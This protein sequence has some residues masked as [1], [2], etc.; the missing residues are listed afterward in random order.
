MSADPRSPEWLAEKGIDKAIWDARGCKRYERGDRWVKEEFREFLPR[1]RLG[2]VTKVVN[3]SA[4]WFMPKHAPPGF[5]PIPPQL[6]PDKPVITTC[7]SGITACILA[8]GFAILGNEYTAVY[9]GSWAEWAS[10]PS[11][12][13]ATD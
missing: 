4:G 7:G 2:T 13:V 1:T 3:Q 12:P 10:V 11:A 8:L 5:P 9:D 6:R